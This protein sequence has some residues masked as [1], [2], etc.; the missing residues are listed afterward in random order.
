MLALITAGI[1]FPGM[2]LIGLSDDGSGHIEKYQFQVRGS[3]YTAKPVLHQDLPLHGT[4]GT[5]GIYAAMSPDGH[6]IAC[7]YENRGIH[8][9]A[10]FGTDHL[11]VQGD[12]SAEGPG[13]PTWSPDGTKIALPQNGIRIQIIDIALRRVLASVEAS[14]EFAWSRDSRNL[15]FSGKSQPYGGGSVRPQ[16]WRCLDTRSKKLSNTPQ[17]QML[18]H[19]GL[20]AIAHQRRRA[21]GYAGFLPASLSTNFGQFARGLTPAFEDEPEVDELII[22]ASLLRVSRPKSR[23]PMTFLWPTPSEIFYV[24]RTSIFS[25]R[26]PPEPAV[27]IG[28]FNVKSGKWIQIPVAISPRSGLLFLASN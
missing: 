13:N 1:L 28:R 12:L 9:L 20:K 15:Y 10:W 27:W 26:D 6:R 4:F 14:G 8:R 21:S 11:T 5:G 19:T 24:S 18:T 7:V 25:K 16:Q 17:E 3:A 2:F 23:E 22:G